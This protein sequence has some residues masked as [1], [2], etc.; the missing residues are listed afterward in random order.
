MNEKRLVNVEFGG[1]PKLNV[2]IEAWDEVEVEVNEKGLVNVE[3]GGLPKQ[4]VGIEDWDV[5]EVEVD[6]GSDVLTDLEESED[7]KCPG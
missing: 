1:L 2:G 3:F 5:V 6:L 7:E 4:N